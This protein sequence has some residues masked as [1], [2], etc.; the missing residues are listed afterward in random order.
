MNGPQP[1][2]LT[3]ELRKYLY[4]RGQSKSASKPR[5]KS[6][7]K[8]ARSKTRSTSKYAIV[9]GRK[10][11]RKYNTDLP[12]T[13][14]T[15]LGTHKHSSQMNASHHK[16]APYPEKQSKNKS[17]SKSKGHKLPVPKFPSRTPFN[18]QHRDEYI[19]SSLSR[20]QKRV[21]LADPYSQSQSRNQSNLHQYTLLKYSRNASRNAGRSNNHSR[22]ISR[23]SV[24]SDYCYPTS[25]RCLSINFPNR[26]D[27]LGR[28]MNNT[29]VG[30]GQSMTNGIGGG[31]RVEQVMVSPPGYSLE[32]DRT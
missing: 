4:H 1:N 22:S 7:R 10:T 3:N 27:H 13:P 19:K 5:T 21:R 32:C 2:L 25:T 8:S 16:G 31:A 28:R 15:A 23:V 30:F 24:R 9:N 18:N 6:K 17:R 29:P 12:K 14:T 20:S 26:S 11:S